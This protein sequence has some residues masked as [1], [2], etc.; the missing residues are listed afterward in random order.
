[1]G[2][3]DGTYHRVAYCDVVA[4][5]NLGWKAL[6]RVQEHTPHGYYGIMVKWD[7]EGDPVYPGK[8]PQP[9]AKTALVAAVVGEGDEVFLMLSDGDHT[10]ERWLLTESL[11]R[12]ILLE[13]VPMVLR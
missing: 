12:K 8:K 3:F 9:D 13:L 5:E 7:R 4:W 10:C 1:M 6:P 2:K 11:A